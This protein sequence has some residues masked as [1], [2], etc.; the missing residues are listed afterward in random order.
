MFLQIGEPYVHISYRDW[1]EPVR[2]W[3][4]VPAEVRTC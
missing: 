2:Y 3:R 1:Y 4:F